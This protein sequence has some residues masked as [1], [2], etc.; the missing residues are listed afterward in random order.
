MNREKVWKDAKC[1]YHRFFLWGRGC[2]I[3]RS[4]ISEKR[5]EF[6]TGVVKCNFFNCS[7]T[8]L[9]FFCQCVLSQLYKTMFH[10]KHRWSTLKV[11]GLN[12]DQK[13]AV[14]VIGQTNFA[15]QFIKYAL[16]IQRF[17]QFK[18]ARSTLFLNFIEGHLWAESK[19]A[20]NLIV[21]EFL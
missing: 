4:V 8:D 6:I 20:Q 13:C 12:L 16:E 7:N 21:G 5:K 9:F 11:K 18:L 1:I 10:H 15:I 3:R 14:R 2:W 19:S 17:D